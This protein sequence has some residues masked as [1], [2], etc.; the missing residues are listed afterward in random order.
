MIAERFSRVRAIQLLGILLLGST[1]AQAQIANFVDDFD[2]PVLDSGW[3]VIEPTNHVGFTGTGFYEMQGS[4]TPPNS[5]TLQRSPG[6]TNEDFTADVTF[7]LGGTTGE[8][9]DYKF[10]FLATSFMEIVAN[11][12]TDNIRVFSGELGQNFG[13]VAGVGLGDGTVL[14]LRLSYDASEGTVKI[15]YSVGSDPL[16]LLGSATGLNN[17]QV[18]NIDLNV[19]RI[20]G[21]GFFTP[22]M[23]LD[24]FEIQ[25]Q[26]V[27][28]TF[29]AFEDPFDGPAL[30]PSWDLIQSQPG[31]HVGF[32]GG[33]Y[34]VQKTTTSGEA[35]LSRDFGGQAD[36]F[37]SVEFQMQDFIGSDSRVEFRNPAP[38]GGITAVLDSTGNVRVVSEELG[39]TVADLSGFSYT[40]GETLEFSVSTDSV[41]GLTEVGLIRNG[42][43]PLLLASLNG[44]TQFTPTNNM[45]VVIKSGTGNG[46]SPRLLFDHYF[47]DEGFVG[48]DLTPFVEEFT[49]PALDSSWFTSDSGTGSLVGFND[50]GQYEISTD[51]NVTAGVS[52][53]IGFAGN[54]TF[55]LTARLNDFLGTDTD[56]RL[57]LTGGDALTVILRSDDTLG[58][59]SDEFGSVYNSAGL[60]LSDGDLVTLQLTIETEFGDWEVG[61]GINGAPEFL[62][63]DFGYSD[64]NPTQTEIEVV[65]GSGGGAARGGGGSGTQP[66]VLLDQTTVSEG[67]SL[68]PQPAEAFSDDFDSAPLDGN[69]N[70][71]GLSHL[72]HTN[73]MYYAMRVDTNA[74]VEMN[75]FLAPNGFPGVPVGSFSVNAD[76]RFDD[77]VGAGDPGGGTDF[78]LKIEFTG[79]VMEIVFNSFRTI[80]F[81]TS[82]NGQAWFQDTFTEFTDGDTVNFSIVYDASGPSVTMSVGLNGGDT[83][84]RETRSNLVG[85]TPELFKISGFRFNFDN[86]GLQPTFLIDNLEIN[87]GLAGVEPGPLTLTPAHSGLFELIW[88]LGVLQTAPDITGPWSDVTGCTSP[89]LHN[90]TEE[91]E[92]FR[93]EN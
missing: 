32:G 40:D 35:G 36:F 93:A 91:L 84:F 71:T 77:L 53:F 55:T 14:N 69:W 85:V 83:I 31:D 24:R 23:L 73:S 64:L 86:P 30:D 74:Q 80:R 11:P 45:T 22:V 72:G 26:V 48:I 29:A 9:V 33:L 87:P 90:P 65:R 50:K 81:F 41:N 59:I 46:N 92:F 19:T 28:I 61:L 44:L 75:R 62:A 38:G 58:V 18:S 7:E 60:G 1:A 10:R 67:F 34:E 47:L 88:D 82:N 66:S 43:T 3:L 54:S 52:R 6:A 21:I 89:Y 63:S 2:G 15:G 49:G 20:S 27:P 76:V 8:S 5:A 56:L 17:F 37:S 25:D 42:G 70:T 57:A 79:G 16:T 78:K 68:I 4:T 39:T 13:D 12:Q 51:T